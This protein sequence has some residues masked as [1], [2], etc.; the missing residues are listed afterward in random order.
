MARIKGRRAGPRHKCGPIHVEVAKDIVEAAVRNVLT[1]WLVLLQAGELD[2]KDLDLVAHACQELAETAPCKNCLRLVHQ[3]LGAKPCEECGTRDPWEC[4]GALA[5]T[6]EEM[7]QADLH[8]MSL[9]SPSQ[10]LH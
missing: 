4:L 7:V 10:E 6:I 2:T 3:A 8:M 5:S 9:V 1:T